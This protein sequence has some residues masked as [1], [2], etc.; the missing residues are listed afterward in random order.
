QPTQQVTTDNFDN[1]SESE[2]DAQ[3]DSYAIDV[4]EEIED[5]A[6]SD[7]GNST[8]SE[9]ESGENHNTTDDES[10]IDV[11]DESE[12]ESGDDIDGGYAKNYD[13]QV[14]QQGNIQFSVLQL[15]KRIR[16]CIGNIRA[17]RAVLDYVKK[18][19]QSVDPPIT[20]TLITDIEIRWNTTFVMIDRFTKHRAIIDDING[21]PYQIPNTS[22]TQQLK[23][24]S[25]EF[26][27]TNNDWHRITDLKKALEP[28]MIS[29]NVV[30]AKNY[31][32]LAAAYS[33]EIF[34]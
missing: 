31:P 18:K 5:E 33:G 14:V 9:E 24:G 8:D 27:F 1:T 34:I 3:S 26:E 12:D 23:I 19:A 6:S 7:N 13:E 16:S 25:K 2:N 28:F 4:P 30:S 15:V 11:E 22:S 20:S 32:T 10:N 17:K 29:T 21:R